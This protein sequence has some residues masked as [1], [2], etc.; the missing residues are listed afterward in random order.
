MTSIGFIGLGNMGGPMARNLIAGGHAVAGFEVVAAA[1]DRAV[2]DGT[3]AA[4]SATEAV[5]AVPSPTV[6]S[7]AAATMSNPATAWPAAH[8]L[9]AIGPPMLPRPM[10]P[11]EVMGASS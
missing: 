6:R 5:A 3:T 7:S 9:R 2:G 11:I 10:K 8:K 1:L 4:A